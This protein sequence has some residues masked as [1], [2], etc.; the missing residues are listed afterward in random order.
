MSKVVKNAPKNSKMIFPETQKNIANAS[1]KKVLKAITDDVGIL[2][3]E[4]CDVSDKEQM[5]VL[6]HYVDKRGSVLER[7]IKIVHVFDTTASSL[8]E[9]ICTLLS[10]L[11]LSLSRVLV[12]GYDGATRCNDD[13]DW[14]FVLLSQSCNIVRGKIKTLKMRCLFVKVANDC[15]QALRDN[16]WTY[17]LDEV[18]S[19][20][21]KH[22]INIPNMEDRF[23]IQ[24]KSA[25]KAP[26]ITHLHRYRVDIF[27]VI[28]GTQL[29]ELNSR[30]DEINSEL[31]CVACLNPRDSFQAFDNERLVKLASFYPREF[32]NV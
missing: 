1:A 25:C 32:S 20:C 27:C 15:L 6:L 13:A 24:G 21:M 14:V 2:V 26:H 9:A 8:K 16:G 29:Q 23:V 3:D 22:E 7:F 28:I 12:Q 31:L 10:S 4:S 17:L 19:F 5:A 11:N 18:S 30:F